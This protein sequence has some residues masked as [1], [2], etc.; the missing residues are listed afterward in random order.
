MDEVPHLR[1]LEECLKFEM[2]K[3]KN[4]KISP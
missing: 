2:P 1:L 4:L 3:I